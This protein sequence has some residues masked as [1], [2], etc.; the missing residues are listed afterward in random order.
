MNAKNLEARQPPMGTAAGAALVS[1]LLPLLAALAAIAV[2]ALFF[3]PPAAAQTTPSLP[4]SCAAGGSADSAIKAVASTSTT[5]TVT[6]SGLMSVA[7]AGDLR[8]CAPDASDVYSSRSVETYSVGSQPAEDD[9]REITGLTPD[10]DYWVRMTY[11]NSPPWHYIR[12]KAAGA[13]PTITIAAGTSPVTEGTAAQ[14][15]VTA[16]PAPSANLTVNLTVA[17]ASGSDFVASGDE[18]SKTLTITAS[19]TTATYSVTTQ[20][21]TTDEPNGD[22]SVTVGTGTG[23][24]VGSTASA[25][26]TVNDDDA[27]VTTPPDALVSNTGQS[28]DDTSHFGV[29]RAQSFTT[30]SNSSGYTL[31]SLT[32]PAT[33]T[34]TISVTV[35]IESSD[36]NSKPGGSLGALTLTQSGTTLT[37]TTAGIDLTANTTYFVVLSGGATGNGYHRTNSDNEDAGA[38]AGWS[39]GNSSLWGGA[40]WNST[41]DTVL[42]LAVHGSAKTADSTPPTFSSATVNGATLKVVFDEDLDTGSVPAP[43]DFDVQV[44]GSSR[45]VASSG[46]AIADAT[47]TLTLSSAAAAGEIVTVAYTKPAAN[48]LQDATGNDVADFTAQTVTNNTPATTP[49]GALVSNTGQTDVEFTFAAD[50]AQA[51]TTG[52]NAAGYTLTRVDVFMRAGASNN[53][54]YTAVGIHADASG[55]PGDSEG[56]LST[57]GSPPAA[58][59]AVQLAASGAGIALDANTTYW[60]VLDLSASSAAKLFVTDSD[61]EDPGAAAG[62]SIADG[63]RFRTATL[64]AWTV[65]TGTQPQSV[66]LAVH[67]SAKTATTTPPAA[68]AAPTVAGVFS[69]GMEVSWAAPASLGTGTAVTDYDLRYFAGAADPANEADWVEEG[70]TKGPPNP[71]TNTSAIITGLTKDQAYRVQVRAAAGHGESPWSASVAGTPA[72]QAPRVLVEKSGVCR[73]ATEA[74]LASALDSNRAGATFV[75]LELSGRVANEWT[76]FPATCDPF[77]DRDGDALTYAIDLSLVP[78]NVRFAGNTPTASEGRVFVAAFVARQQ[79]LD[80]DLGVTATDPSG[81]SSAKGLLGFE[82]GGFDGSA[83]PSFSDTVAAQTWTRNAEITAL[84]LPAAGGGDLEKTAYNTTA[85]WPYLYEVTGLP[86]GLSFDADSRE[87]TGT[88]TAT[89]SFTATYTAQDADQDTSATDTAS[90][91]FAVTVNAPDTTTPT[92]GALVSNHGQ[93]DDGTAAFANDLAQ[94]FTTGSNTPGYKLTSVEVVGKSTGTAPSYSAAIHEDSSNAPGT[95][96]GDLSAPALAATDAVIKFAASGDGLD[97]DAATTYWLVIDNSTETTTATIKRTSSTA[98]DMGAAAGWSIG[99]SRLF[100]AFGATAWTSHTQPLEIG[101]HGTANAD[102][103]TF[104]GARVIGDSLVIGFSEGLDTTSV[105]APG[106]FA[107]KVDGI[108]RTVASGGVTV[109]DTFVNLTLSSAVTHGQ[110]VAV[111]YTKP[112]ANPLQD[113]DGDAVVGGVAWPV[114]NRTLAPAPPGLLVSN[115]G[116]TVSNLIV[117]SSSASAEAQGFTTGSNSAGYALTSV[118]LNLFVGNSLNTTE[119]DYTVSIWSSDSDGHPDTSLGTL[120]NPGVL[121]K[122]VNYF[123]ASGTGIDLDAETTYLVVLAV[124]SRGDI[125]PRSSYTASDNEDAGGATG[126]T[127]GNR[128]LVEGSG[129]WVPFNL[130]ISTHIAVHGSEKDSAPPTVLSA[131]V[132]GATLKVVFNEDLDT[133]SVP[134]PGDFGVQVDDS[135]RS[136]DTNGVAIAADTVTLT[137]SSAVTHG[138]AVTVAYTKPSANPLQDAAGNAVADFAAQSVANDTPAPTVTVPTVSVASNGNITAGSPASFTVSASPAPSSNIDIGLALTRTGGVLDPWNGTVRIQASTTSATFTSANTVSGTSGS[139]TLTLQDGDGYSVPSSNR[140][141][142][143][144][145][146][147]ASGTDPETSPPAIRGA[148]VSGSRVTITLTKKLDPDSVPPA[149]AFTVTVDGSPAT[150]TGVRIS[151]IILTLEEPVQ[152]GQPVTVAYDRAR[153]GNSPLRDLDGNELDSFDALP[154]R[155]DTPGP[156]G[157]RDPLPLQ[158]ALWTGVAWIWWTAEIA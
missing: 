94:P 39:V 49:A 105:P 70:E 114:A 75:S 40:P 53:P 143:V 29:A 72:N 123:K 74:D 151:S 116:Q 66:K 157:Q 97:L 140:S 25:S 57:P 122:G 67:A 59:G 78:D 82:G 106:D 5:I 10:K 73:A 44:A 86:A 9:T 52:S 68:P 148:T 8:I 115:T 14:F 1:R 149:D 107:V 62:W 89:G 130:D 132:N 76:E 108:G 28:S 46:V 111:T 153:A 95:K 45:T 69:S 34:A 139:V 13:G 15:T 16:N 93:A 120:T 58:K 118:G 22:V 138:E 119:P 81:L 156:Q 127:V 85:T 83:T 99:D 65:S 146:T 19:S 32:I 50:F 131:R 87:I 7:Y 154:V 79:N 41:S 109:V 17:D 55:V 61:S 145:V 90:L 102:P 135:S 77:D 38:A 128:G 11:A 27:P 47:V 96:V 12:T 104:G 60:L 31:T 23:Y 155:R 88:P 92:P 20:A 126:W 121:G 26:V 98:E 30:G 91:T 48:P 63:L 51:F 4:A 103:P 129:G 18:G 21:D 100:R 152:D 37:G 142:T 35:R 113:A 84:T 144:T 112:S 64:T 125:D 117:F 124:A 158:L 101:V 134:A 147:A 24:T 80:F 6:F 110:S 36:S 137:L 71:G 150:V 43:G 54:A 3:A 56:A 141:A 133:G 136:V 2:P 33:H 42:M